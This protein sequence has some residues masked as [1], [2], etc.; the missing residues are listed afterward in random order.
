MLQS[1]AT[2]PMDIAHVIQQAVAP[3]F[4]LSGVAAMLVVL[5]NRLARVIDRARQFEKDYHDLPAGEERHDMRR[6]LAVLSRRS[7]LSNLAITL[8]TLCALLICL[9]IVT[10]F[11][12]AL[13]DVSAS[14][15]IAGL[16]IVAM[17]ALI[18]GLL[19][20]LQEIFVATATVRIN[21]PQD[22]PIDM[23]AESQ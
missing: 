9:L 5:T 12:S 14:R 21:P 16:F 20:F 22:R 4:L 11:V 6:R 1:P 18:G 2:A 19:T 10:L 15:W 7:R 23:P 13:L 17:L 8:C 3:V